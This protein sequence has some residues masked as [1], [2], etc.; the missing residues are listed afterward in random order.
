MRWELFRYDAGKCQF[1]HASDLI[2]HAL[3]QV[4]TAGAL[5][6]V[7]PDALLAAMY[8]PGGEGG[9]GSAGSLKI[10]TATA[11]RNHM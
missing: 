2:A 11:R 3:A 9:D 8:Q 10:T 5:K 1:P 6:G 7:G 4:W